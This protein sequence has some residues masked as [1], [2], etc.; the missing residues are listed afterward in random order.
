MAKAK[1]SKNEYGTE[2]DL[3]KV[4]M[5]I[6]KGILFKGNKGALNLA[7]LFG[8]TIMILIYVNSLYTIINDSVTA[9]SPTMDDFSASFI[10]LLP[11]GLLIFLF[12][13]LLFYFNS[14]Y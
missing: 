9:A 11:G 1:R 2:I 4:K 7:V 10:Q 12:A 13:Y 14:E 6:P 5:K 8:L 3:T